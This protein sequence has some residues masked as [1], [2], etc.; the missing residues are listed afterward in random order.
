V[1]VD[2]VATSAAAP[3]HVAPTSPGQPVCD[4][5]ARP[6]NAHLATLA[7]PKERSSVVAA[8]APSRLA[9]VMRDGVSLALDEYGARLQPK[10]SALIAD[11]LRQHSQLVE[12]LAE[13]WNALS[14][15]SASEVVRHFKAGFSSPEAQAGT[16]IGSWLGGIGGLAGGV[17]GALLAL[18][19]DD[20]TFSA[21]LQ[22]YLGEVDRWFTVA[23]ADFD[24][25]VL[26]KVER[27][28]N[29]WPYRLRWMLG[30]AL[31]LGAAGVAAWLAR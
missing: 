25:R 9:A 10:T 18:H 21:R 26:P 23:A 19:R 11:W 24:S 14:Q 12:R 4:L 2:G 22:T 6:Y 5:I 7:E 15:G 28:L 27:D 1:T 29:P 30:A 8:L 13:P 17:L 16:A 20:Q 3:A 31:T